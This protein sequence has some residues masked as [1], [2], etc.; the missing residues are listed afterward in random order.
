MENELIDDAKLK[1]E[2]RIRGAEEEISEAEIEIQKYREDIQKIA[3]KISKSEELL[4]KS[5]QTFLAASDEISQAEEKRSLKKKLEAEKEKFNAEDEINRIEK[6]L[7]GQ[8]EK[9]AN[10]REKIRLKL[11]GIDN[12]KLAIRDAEDTIWRDKISKGR[13]REPLISEIEGHLTYL[14]TLP[15]IDNR[16]WWLELWIKIALTFFGSFYSDFHY[17]LCTHFRGKLTLLFS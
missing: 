16:L 6:G 5:K 2:E 12:L 9:I 1:P 11:V 7:S 10:I 13:E 15:L 14:N 8:R 17:I 3:D 4:N